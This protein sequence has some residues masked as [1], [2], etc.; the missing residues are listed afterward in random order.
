[1]IT[2]IEKYRAE[3][4]GTKEDKEIAAEILQNTWEGTEACELIE[5]D[6][7]AFYKEKGFTEEELNVIAKR[8]ADAVPEIYFTLDIMHYDP[9]TTAK[10]IKLRI[11]YFSHK[12]DVFQ[13][14]V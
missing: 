5:P 2:T 1:M 9:R 14:I 10:H 3:F 13:D 6:V 4:A 7:W 12:I 11:R 8:I